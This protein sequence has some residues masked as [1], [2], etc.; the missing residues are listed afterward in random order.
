MYLFFLFSTKSYDGYS[1]YNFILYS[2]S[3]I[4]ILRRNLNITAVITS[5][6]YKYLLPYGTI[7]L[8]L[9]YF[10]IIVKFFANLHTS[11]ILPS[12]LKNIKTLENQVKNENKKSSVKLLYVNDKYL[13]F[14]L[15]DKIKPRKGEKEKPE[16]IEIVKFEELFTEN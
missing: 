13:F 1:F 7:V 4:I 2:W 14:E 10:L 11:F 16:Q 3:A 5:E 8:Y 12:N 6:K 9:T 15:K